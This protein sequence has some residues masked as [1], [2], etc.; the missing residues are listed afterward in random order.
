MGIKK[1]LKSSGNH[2][3]IAIIVAISLTVLIGILA[4][5]IDGGYLYA[6]KNKWQ[7]GVEAAAMAGAFAM[8]DDD[9]EAVAVAQQIA[10]ENGLPFTEMEGLIILQG[11]YDEK[12]QY[13]DFPVYKDFIDENHANFPDDEYNNAVMVSL[14]ADV[15]T[16]LAGIFG[17]DEV[18]VSASA[19]AYLKRYGIVSLNDEIYLWTGIYGATVYLGFKNGDL[20]ANGDI[21]L[22]NIP[23]LGPPI[24]E[25]GKAYAH[26]SIL[27]CTGTS[28]DPWPPSGTNCSDVEVDGY[29]PE[30][31]EIT[32][33]P[34]IDEDWDSL[35]NDPGV[36]TYTAD[37]AGDDNI[38][39]GEG[40]FGPGSGQLEK[41][42]Y[43]FDIMGEGSQDKTYFIDIEPGF[44]SDGRLK[45]ALVAETENTCP[46]HTPNGTE[47]K[48]ITFISRLPV[49]LNTAGGADYGGEDQDQ[50][51][52]ITPG[53]IWVHR[54]ALHL[55]GVYFRAGEY[56]TNFSSSSGMAEPKMRVITD[57]R[58]TLYGHS[59]IY[60]AKFGPPCPPA[61]ARLGKLEIA[62]G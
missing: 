46:G 11:F 1:W 54:Q 44:H 22:R 4:I 40:M 53:Y 37:D 13:D 6:S 26:E 15:S 58:I 61:I 32:E 14:N 28:N 21:K 19:V 12:D 33:I 47:A 9:F 51:N 50:V 57:E 49:H 42:A 30:A 48:G 2:G 5:I 18:Q 59:E 16:F 27:S 17:K 39:C 8:C 56:F 23:T 20:H 62:G 43:S 34:P 31:A 25:N 10:Q 60:D 3:N 35:R 52:F 24:L 55:H 45:V 38:F 41:H 36:I 29:I 7:N